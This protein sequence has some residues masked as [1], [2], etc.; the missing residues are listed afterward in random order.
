ML[1]NVRSVETFVFRE[2]CLLSFMADGAVPAFVQP[3]Q[4]WWGIGLS[5]PG[6]ARPSIKSGL[7]TLGFVCA[8]PLAFVACLVPLKLFGL[9]V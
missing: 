9:G 4:G 5:F 1:G 2:R 6:C 3:F 8:M 7:A